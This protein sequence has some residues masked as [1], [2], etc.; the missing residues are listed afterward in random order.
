MPSPSA[1]FRGLVSRILPPAM[2]DGPDSDRVVRLGRYGDQ[3]VESMWPSDHLL[4]DEGSIVVATM[5]PGQTA[6]QL[7]LSA[8]FSATA[9]AFVLVN[10]D[11][12]GG[13]RCYLKSL[14]LASLTVP[15]SGTD[16]RYA[17]VIDSA[18]RTPTTISNA[19]NSDRGPGTAA[20]VT[21]YRALSFITNQDINDRLQVGIPY[22][23]FSTSGGAPPTVPGAGPAA[24]TIVGNGYIK[25]SIPVTKDQYFVQF[26]GVD[27]GGTYQSAAALAKIVEH[28]PAVVIGPG[29]TALIYLWSNGNITAG[30]AFDDAQLVWVER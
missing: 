6:L 17:V 25:N 16:L 28:A 13:K 21:A 15:T 1:L 26:G 30:N 23:P 4:A 18:N 10:S 5:M 3:R 2:A 24:R 11:V 8:S 12:A 20:T 27:A 22:F 29:Q 19:A 14:K 7:G 9:A